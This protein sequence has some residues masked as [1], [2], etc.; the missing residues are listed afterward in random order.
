MWLGTPAA[1]IVSVVG[2]FHDARIGYAVAGAVV[3]GAAAIVLI[4]WP[5]VR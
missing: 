1:L 4:L 3:S 2:I 5:M